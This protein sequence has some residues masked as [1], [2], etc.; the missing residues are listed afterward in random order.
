MKTPETTDAVS[1]VI[2]DSEKARQLVNAGQ[3]FAYEQRGNA[4]GRFDGTYKLSDGRIAELYIEFD[5]I[6][7]LLVWANES[8]WRKHNQFPFNA[9]HEF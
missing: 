6:N 2:N 4:S 9:Y 3:R 1:E 5:W 8:D 7:K